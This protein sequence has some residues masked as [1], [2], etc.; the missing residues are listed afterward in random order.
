[1]I[2]S[3]KT[4]SNCSHYVHNLHINPLLAEAFVLL[5][6]DPSKDYLNERCDVER[7]IVR[8]LMFMGMVK[9]KFTE[10][11]MQCPIST[12]EALCHV[13]YCL[14]KGQGRF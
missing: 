11:D 5:V 14:F 1:M 4:P 7:V 13:H 3:I 12:F 9:S 2:K 10:D 8:N 6:I